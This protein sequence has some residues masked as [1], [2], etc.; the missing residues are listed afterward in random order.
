MV[1]LVHIND[2]EGKVG[3]RSSTVLLT[4]GLNSLSVGEGSV[5]E[6]EVESLGVSSREARGNHFGVGVDD[7]VQGQASSLDGVF[8]HFYLL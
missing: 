8:V 6:R 2:K 7:S 1:E 4:L 3:G 5:L